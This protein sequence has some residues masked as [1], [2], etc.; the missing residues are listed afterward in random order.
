MELT[1]PR[2]ILLGAGTL[3]AVA[4]LPAVRSRRVML[5]TARSFSRSE[6][7]EGFSRGLA[8]SA[9]ALTRGPDVHGEPPVD[10]VDELAGLA[11]GARV[12]CVVAVGGGS[13]LDAAKAAALL[14]VNEGRAEDYQ[15]GR[16]QAVR[17]ALPVVAAP[18]TAG[19]GSEG[20]GIAV[21]TNLG[22]GIKKAVRHASMTPA[23][24]VLDPR[25]TAGLPPEVAAMTAVDALSHALESLVSRNAGDLTRGYS[26]QALRLIGQ[27]VRPAV[28][29]PDDAVARERM[30]CAACLAGISL[31]GGVGAMHL[32]AQ[33]VS[34]VTGFP[35]SRS[36]ASLMLEVVRYNMSACR[37]RYDEAAR[38]LGGRSLPT[39]LKALLHD[40]GLAA[41]TQGRTLSADE[42]DA[43][44]ASVAASQSH[45]YALNPRPMTPEDARAL[46]LRAFAA[47]S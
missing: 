32:L 9:E 29:D 38:A 47:A 42:A 4:G 40:I 27:A 37:A 25:L 12:E 5:V 24:A 6:L 3:D 28:H 21:L 26:L 19:T 8:A 34:V 16:R 43:V 39:T 14:A 7:C 31:A 17:D 23:A 46:L 2:Q 22:Q 45:I 11:R 15:L 1:L 18:T 35:H 36:I 30:L 41:P 13:T 10:L 20:N 33:P 44:M